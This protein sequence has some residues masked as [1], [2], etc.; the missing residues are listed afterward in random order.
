[1]E[2]N[3]VISITWSI[4]PQ[5]LNYKH[6]LLIELPWQLMKPVVLLAFTSNPVLVGRTQ[7]MKFTLDMLDAVISWSDLTLIID[8]ENLEI[9]VL[10][11]LKI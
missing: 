10:Y 3:N 4:F 5:V 9:I 2:L 8:I 11:T 6:K 7:L 1:M